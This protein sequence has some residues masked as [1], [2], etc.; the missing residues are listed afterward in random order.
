MT[1][2]IVI[3]LFFFPALF[4]VGG[5]YKSAMPSYF[6]FAVIYT[7]F[8]LKGK[9]AFVMTFVELFVYSGLCA[10]AYLYPPAVQF[11]EREADIV[12]DIVVGFV[13]VG[14]MLGA[15][16]YRHFKE[17]DDQRR[18]LAEANGALE[19]VNQLKTE[20]FA[21]ASH[22]MRTP[23]TVISVNVQTVTD[24]LEELSLKDEEA[25]HLLK[26]TQIEVMRLARMVGGMLTLASMSEIRDRQEIDLTSLLQSGVEMLRHTLSRRGNEIEAEIEKGLTVFGNAD[27]LAQV[28]INLIQNAGVH[29][30]NGA[31]T[32]SA[33][34][35]GDTI[36]VTVRDTG[37][38]IAPELLPHVFE[39]GVSTG[40]TGFGLHLCKTAI[41][42]HSG[43][44][45]IESEL[46]VGTTVF[47]TLPVYAGQLG[48]EKV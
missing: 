47:Y 41:E 13:V 32:V 9:K 39:R 2:I 40:G 33:M 24:I 48:G 5:G 31:V 38:G 30:E 15:A 4:F 7:V 14:I 21:N 8:M 11:L 34:K 45:W 46:G 29:T 43:E 12:R 28:L 20:F 35:N 26:N 25:S 44:I 27:L 10:Y 17:Y 1:T 3:F 37:T 36:T 6:I 18:Q 16:L 22:E 23:L 19:R 42:S